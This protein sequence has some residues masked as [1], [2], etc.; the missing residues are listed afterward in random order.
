MRPLPISSAGSIRKKCW[1]SAAGTASFP[2]CTQNRDQHATG[3]SSSPIRL[4]WT[5]ARHNSSA[6]SLTRTCT[7]PFL[8]STPLSIPTWRKNSLSLERKEHFDNGHSIFYAA[9]KMGRDAAE[10]PA[11]PQ[12]HA[13]YKALFLDYITFH[14]ELVAQLNSAMRQA[15]APVFLFGA[16]IFSL[17]LI[18]F[19]LETEKIQSILD[20]DPHKQGKRLYGTDL[21]VSSPRILKDVPQ[22]NVILRAGVFNEEIKKDILENINPAVVFWE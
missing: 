19:G 3:R 6:V 21:R 7:A 9:R 17:Y 18:N 10:T 20:N 12:L 8:P 5:A 2:P 22:A 11:P 16:H 15:D 14:E 13:A 4:L 1:R